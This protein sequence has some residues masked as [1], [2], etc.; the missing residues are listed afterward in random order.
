M[1]IY[2]R[3]TGQYIP[4]LQLGVPDILGVERGGNA[5]AFFIEVKRP[6]NKLSKHQ[7]KFI[8]IAKGFGCK[9]MVAYNIE[10]VKTAG[11]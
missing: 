6:G 1:G 2:K 5:K 11:L 4:S 3:E 8:E 9:A 10:D 7:E